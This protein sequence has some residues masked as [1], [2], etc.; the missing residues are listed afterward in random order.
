M[1]KY[2]Q[3]VILIRNT[4][5]VIVNKAKIIQIKENVNEKNRLTFFIHI[6]KK[7]PFNIYK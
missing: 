7:V 3:L 1:L 6:D 5:N 4:T 2:V